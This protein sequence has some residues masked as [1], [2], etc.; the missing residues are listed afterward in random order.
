MYNS[1]EERAAIEAV[2]GNGHVPGV[3]VGVGSEIPSEVAPARARQK[4]GL[5][6][7]FLVYIGRIDANKGLSG[8]LRL[9]PPIP[10]R[11]RARSRTR[12]D[13]HGGDADPCAPTNSPS[14]LRRRSRQVRRVGGCGNAGHAVLLREP[15]DGRARGVGART[16]GPGQRTVRRA[17]RPVPSKQC[18]VV[19][20]RTSTDFMAAL[21]RLLD[22]RGAGRITRPQRPGLLQTPLQLAGD[23]AQVFRHV[24]PTDVRIRAQLHGTAAGMVGPASAHGAGCGRRRGESAVRSRHERPAAAEVS[25]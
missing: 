15:L 7:P 6:K 2:S 23:R 13:R 16:P 22:D 17:A 25:A 21:D 4:F 19:S 5:S 11:I 24:R 20:T 12:L 14:R 9:L 18:G 8:A 1:P 10:R 3:V